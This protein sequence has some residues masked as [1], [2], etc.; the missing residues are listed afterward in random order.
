MESS[1][2][3]FIQQFS[4]SSVRTNFMYEKEITEI[5]PFVVFLKNKLF[6]VSK[7]KRQQENILH[8]GRAM[9]S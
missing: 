8:V 3:S 7:S 9:S 5:M 2:A 6:A 4:L 1:I